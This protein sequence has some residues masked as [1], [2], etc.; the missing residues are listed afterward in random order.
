MKARTMRKSISE[1]LDLKGKVALVTGG[2]MG[3]GLGISDRLSEAGA[4]VMIVD[5]DGEAGRKAAAS[6]QALGRKVSHTVC[7][8]S[9]VNQIQKAVQQTVTEFSGLD[10]LV[11]NAGVFPFSP[12]LETT[13][14]LWDKVIDTNLK[15]A[16]FFAQQ[17]AV[18]MKSRGVQG[19]IINI[20]SIDALH[21]SGNLVHYDASKGGML[22]MTRSM[23]L[24][25]APH[26]IHVNG[27]AP[28]GIETP[29]AAK[30]MGDMAG[31]LGATPAVL[32]E[33]SKAFSA[34][35]PMKRQGTP[36]DIASVVLFLASDAARYITGETIVVD[37]GYLLS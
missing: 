25:L 35:I 30:I 1:M 16:F 34:R 15:G 18:S 26:G 32:A 31:A 13:E 2:A 11:N 12:V 23:A 36:D 20:A 21:P 17:A 33:M 4:A 27:I 9:S 28:G 19:Q 29:G 10:I 22:M 6:L 3:I 37:G 24:E 8:V 7:D 5:R 14:E